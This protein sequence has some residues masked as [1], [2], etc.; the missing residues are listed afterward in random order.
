MGA[1]AVSDAT[2]TWGERGQRSTE[3]E[4]GVLRRGTTLGRYVLIDLL[5]RGGM[6]AVYAAYD[7]QLERRVAL[8]LLH[9]GPADQV[10]ERVFA[11]A[12]A[13][14]QLRHRNVVAIHD[15]AEL[16]AFVFL[17]MDLAE[18][19]T[20]RDYA[21]AE[22]PPERGAIVALLV[23]CARGLAAVHRAGLVHRDFKPNNVV[24][25]TSEASP[26]AI[27]VDFGL[28]VP[29]ADLTDTPAPDGT[30]EAPALPWAGT[31]AY[32]APECFED[33]GGPSSDQWSFAMTCAELLG[34]RRPTRAEI[35]DGKLPVPAGALRD[36][37]ARGLHADPTRRWE[38]LDA[39][40]DAMEAALRPRNTRRWVAGALIMA[41]GAGGLAWALR[42]DGCEARAREAAD[43]IW[44]DARAQTIAA[45]MEHVDSSVSARFIEDLG[46]WS[47]QWRSTYVDVCGAQKL[48][49][50]AGWCLEDRAN[51]VELVVELVA[52]GS[53]LDAELHRIS[54][55]L[56]RLPDPSGCD[57]P[58]LERRPQPTAQEREAS[59]SR[60]EQLDRA[61]VL[62]LLGQFD[63]AAELAEAAWDDAAP[64]GLR[65]S[66]AQRQASIAWRRGKLDD[67]L[68]HAKEAMRLAAEARDDWLVATVALDLADIMIER[69]DVDALT[70]HLDYVEVAVKRAPPSPRFD[71]RLHFVKGRYHEIALE[72][73]A[74]LREHEHG[75]AIRQESL[76]GSLYVAD[77]EANVGLMLGKLGRLDEALA[78]LDAALAHYRE[79]LGDVHPDIA[80]LCVLRG[81]NLQRMGRNDEAMTALEGC[82]EMLETTVGEGHPKIAFASMVLGMGRAQAGDYE[83]AATLMRR[84]VEIREVALGPEHPETGIAHTNLGNIL[85]ALDDPAAREHLERARAITV[86]TYGE[87]SSRLSSIHAGLGQLAANE[88][89]WKTAHEHY[90]RGLEIEAAAVGEDNPALLVG[91]INL[92][93]TRAELGDT[94]TEATWARAE[95]ILKKAGIESHPLRPIIDV[96]MAKVAIEVGDRDSAAKRLDAALA[97]MNETEPSPGLREEAR[98]LRATVDPQ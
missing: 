37:I 8:K 1:A 69:G 71:A 79:L 58:D 85:A 23:Q 11:E 44:N 7:T 36:V 61:G 28:A 34:G 55:V 53:G 24:V 38:S 82:I 66:I 22:E 86:A 33:G 91:L 90:E 9:R 30:P 72:P 20:L 83:G 94:R 4:R 6:G 21:N 10:A 81:L 45:R 54:G 27:V 40:A 31:P 43:A 51:T 75:L 12:R 95:S 49:S 65:A 19:P 96:G 84:A 80:H 78:T 15:A 98:R 76:P 42:G 47:E 14:A 67:A 97:A 3:E 77:S 56:P 18:G 26:R 32:M 5:G 73:E 88:A 2:S 17:A 63:G 25:D 89:D 39:M 62:E 60:R 52:E 87:D 92:A 74:A 29:D 13:L 68:A 64:I 16:D 70:Q 41:L 59:A 46:A 35:A 50:A 93:Q 57:D 48:E